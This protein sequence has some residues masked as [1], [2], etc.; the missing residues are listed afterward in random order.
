MGQ[1]IKKREIEYQKKKK[2]SLDI[3]TLED[4][5]IN[6]TINDLM[7]VLNNQKDK[8]V[9]DMIEYAEK[10]IKPTKYDKDGNV[11]A[12]KVDYNPIVISNTFF[13]SISPFGARVPLYNAEKLSI[14]F[15]YYM[16]LINEVNDKIGYFPP[17]L[18][19]FCKMLGIALSTLKSYKNSTDLDL[20]YVAEKIYDQIGDENITLSQ[21]GKTKER[22]TIFKLKSQNELVEKV[23]PN[24]NITYKEVV[25]TD[26]INDNL[27]KYK[28]LL[29]KKAKND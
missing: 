29:N 25:N 15:D 19:G 5:Y 14:L 6:G 11:V 20:R 24:V 28:N 8:V 23:N 1:I 27:S 18:T 3:K 12:T 22:T 10:H 2:K 4:F 17:S 9:H 26:R 7:P 13:K 16:E 21:L